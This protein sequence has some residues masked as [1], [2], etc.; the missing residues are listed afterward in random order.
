MRCAV[1]HRAL[2]A[3]ES[4]QRRIGP[5]CWKKIINEEGRKEEERKEQIFIPGFSGDVICRRTE[6]GACTNIPQL[7]VLHS[8][9]GFE[10]GYGGSGPADLALNILLLFTNRKT[11]YVLHQ[12]FKSEFISPMPRKGGEIK[13]EVIQE[14]IEGN[15]PEGKLFPLEEPEA[16]KRVYA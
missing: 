3:I 1:C 13:D 2:T 14:W 11:A 7:E 5:I 15:K 9:T 8:P 10:W 16:F 12:K 4:V 6:D